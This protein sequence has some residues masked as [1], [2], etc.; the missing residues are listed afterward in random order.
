MIRQV[1]GRLGNRLQLK[2]DRRLRKILVGGLT[3]QPFS[4]DWL[5]KELRYAGQSGNCHEP[6]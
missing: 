6:W 2:I 5:F 1:R 3:R 4:H